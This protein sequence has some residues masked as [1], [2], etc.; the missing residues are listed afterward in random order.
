MT[1]KGGKTFSKK[2]EEPMVIILPNQNL[3]WFKYVFHIS[4]FHFNLKVAL[5]LSDT[6]NKLGVYFPDEITKG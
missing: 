5:S 2:R 3:D 4:Y 1:R 6:A